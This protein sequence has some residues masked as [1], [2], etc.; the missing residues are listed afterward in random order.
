MQR[1]VSSPKEYLEAIPSA[2]QPLVQ[3]LRRLIK[4]ESPSTREVIRWGMLCYDDDGT[5]FALAAQ[6]DYVGLYVMATTAMKDLS[7]DLKGIDKGRGC[8]RFAKLQDVPSDTIR[9]LLAR[10]VT[11]RE[12]DGK[13][14]P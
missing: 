3:H 13:P 8:L 14:L 10:A 7:K 12:V 6:K 2:Q 9:K 5:L 11:L 1:N 4:E